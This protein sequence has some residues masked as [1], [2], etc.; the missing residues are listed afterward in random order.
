MLHGLNSTG[1][2]TPRCA[3]TDQPLPPTVSKPRFTERKPGSG[4]LSTST[5]PK[6]ASR[7]P[8]HLA[9]QKRMAYFRA[10]DLGSTSATRPNFVFPASVPSIPTIRNCS[11]LPARSSIPPLGFSPHVSPLLVTVNAPAGFP[12]SHSSTSPYFASGLL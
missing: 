5:I 9:Q 6:V 2:F 10:S 8:E 1:S 3:K 12:W 4:A 11:G 7:P